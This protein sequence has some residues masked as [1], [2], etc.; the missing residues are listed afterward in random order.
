MMTEFKNEHQ[1]AGLTRA[2]LCVS[3]C[4]SHLH[5]R[6]KFYLVHFQQCYVRSALL[7]FVMCDASDISALKNPATQDRFRAEVGNRLKTNP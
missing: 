7:L 5:T 3:V 1:M 4:G 6:L 2:V